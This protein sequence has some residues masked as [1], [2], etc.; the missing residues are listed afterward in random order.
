MPVV[1]GGQLVVPGDAI[2]ADDDGVAC[3]ERDEVLAV[4]ERVRARLATE[5]EKR[6]LFAA[7]TLSLDL[8]GLRQTLRDL[9]V[10]MDEAESER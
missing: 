9:S 1:C 5:D 8:Y 2:V 4:A 6:A 3:V 7:G 10:E